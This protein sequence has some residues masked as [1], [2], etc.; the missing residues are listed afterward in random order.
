MHASFDG[1]SWSTRHS[2]SSAITA[3][4]SKQ[5]S[6]KPLQI[7]IPTKIKCPRLSRNSRSAQEA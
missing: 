1:Q 3:K 5:E 7:D 2:G 4:Q 6:V